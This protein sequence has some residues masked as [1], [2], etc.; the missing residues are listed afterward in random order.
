MTAP[1]VPTHSRQR[2][3]PLIAWVAGAMVLLT[4][5][6]SVT[7]VVKHARSETKKNDWHVYYEAG[8]AM[9]ARQP[10]YTTEDSIFLTF[11]N[12]PVV[13]LMAMPLAML[14]ELPARLAWYAV[15]LALII[16][17]L[18]LCGRIV[19]PDDH[20]R[21]RWGWTALATA[22]LSAEYIF[23]QLRYGQTTAIYLFL[24]ILAFHLMTRDRP[25]PAGLALAGGIVIKL[26]PVCFA[27]YFVLRRRP[28]IGLAALTA[29]LVMLFLLP[30]VWVGWQENL[31]LLR[32]WPQHLRETETIRQVVRPENQS[33][34]AL[35]GRIFLDVDGPTGADAG[36]SQPTLRRVW[37]TLS[38]LTATIL[39]GYLWRTR[40]TT[41]A[42][43]RNATHLSLLL[44]FMTLFNP[45]AWR[46]NFMALAV[47][48]YFVVTVLHHHRAFRRLGLPMLVIAYLLNC[49]IPNE[50]EGYPFFD[51]LHTAGARLWGTILLALTV[52]LA[53]HHTTRPSISNDLE[54]PA[55]PS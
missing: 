7:R 36:L 41:P 26:V 40:H 29:G 51:H 47:P 20:S 25:F 18:W 1:N 10:I 45:L 12:A 46:Y 34:Y 33:V 39:Y 17:L 21:S 27:P 55:M 48:F 43:A 19:H 42:P 14:P 15:D 9:R 28:L 23:F 2:L 38:I 3:L 24:T 44:I 32:T 11:K 35:L 50:V 13:A 54:I 49:G 22:A 4:L 30:A 52:L 5:A 37:L 8:E 16:G 31:A 53:F 6:I